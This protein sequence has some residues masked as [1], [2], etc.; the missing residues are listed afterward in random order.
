MAMNWIN[1]NHE[2]I[3]IIL[4]AITAFWAI[5]WAIY[6]RSSDAKKPP[7]ADVSPSVVNN[8]GIS[9]G[10]FQDAIAR[11]EKE[12]REELT[13][14]GGIDTARRL[15]LEQQLTDARERQQNIETEYADY[16]SRMAETIES[17]RRLQQEIIPSHVNSTIFPAGLA[18]ADFIE[19]Q[20]LKLRFTGIPIA[21]RAFTGMF[22][23][24]WCTGC[25][26]G[27][28]Q[29]F[30]LPWVVIVPLFCALLWFAFGR[31]PTITFN[32]VKRTVVF[33]GG[34]GIAKSDAMPIM[35]KA[36]RQTNGFAPELWFGARRFAVLPPEQTEDI[37]TRK[38][39][40]FVRALNWDMGVPILTGL[41]FRKPTEEHPS[42]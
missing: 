28:H 3:A 14:G 22:G 1:Q 13:R 29:I 7:K 31:T 17:L 16:K 21:A 41:D 25:A 20:K 40:P 10:E 38:A 15:Q 24:V 23:L 9:L 18:V 34:G 19:G 11:K 37:A 5:V 12:I 33:A 35:I 39:L 4:T 36:K 26:F 2:A 30:G 32:L 6:T 42:E 8:Y 27:T